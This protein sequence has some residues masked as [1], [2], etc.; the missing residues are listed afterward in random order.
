MMRCL[1]LF[2]YAPPLVGRR[3]D[4]AFLDA[5]GDDFLSNGLRNRLILLED[6]REGAAALSDRTDRVRITEHLA[7]RDGSLEEL[8]ASTVF[9][10]LDTTTTLVDRAVRSTHILLRNHDFDIH[11]RLEQLRLSLEE[12][13]LEALTSALN[14]RE[15][16][17]VNFMVR[18]E[19]DGSLDVDDREAT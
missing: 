13:L 16:V 7:E 9:H 4:L 3:T 1:P 14:E 17:R 5:L 18:T 19:V 12:R 6:H 2:C 15:F 10:A 8:D 11:H